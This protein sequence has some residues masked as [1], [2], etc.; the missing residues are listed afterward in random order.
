MKVLH[1]Y[2]IYQASLSVIAPFRRLSFD[3][4]VAHSSG[5]ILLRQT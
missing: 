4:K 3:T 1:L 2:I 5:I